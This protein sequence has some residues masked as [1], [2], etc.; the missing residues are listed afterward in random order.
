MNII[1]KVDDGNIAGGLRTF[2]LR[3]EYLSNP[4]YKPLSLFDFYPFQLRFGTAAGDL[5]IPKNTNETLT[6]PLQISWGR[7]EV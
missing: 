3:S 2:V 5:P 1:F 6:V 4:Y 7:L